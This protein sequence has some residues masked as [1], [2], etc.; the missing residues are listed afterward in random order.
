MVEDSSSRQWI[1]SFNITSLQMLNMS[2]TEF[3]YLW[4]F[5]TQLLNDK[6]I[7]LTGQNFTA[8]IKIANNQ[9]GNGSQFIIQ[10]CEK[11]DKQYMIQSIEADKEA[12]KEADDNDNDTPRKIRTRAAKRKIGEGSNDGKPKR[13]TPNKTHH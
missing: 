5:N 9:N 11:T 3:G 13:N 10:S 12:E 4:E 7:E 2:C 1:T 8:K 6:V